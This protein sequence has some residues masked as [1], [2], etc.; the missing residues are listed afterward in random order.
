M[1]Y[2]TTNL[3]FSKDEYEELRNLAFVE[4]RSIAKI[5]RDAVREYRKSKLSTHAQKMKLYNLMAK[6]RIKINTSTVELVKEGR[7]FE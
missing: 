3:R 1:N 6:S 4:K 5:I 2:V 7:K